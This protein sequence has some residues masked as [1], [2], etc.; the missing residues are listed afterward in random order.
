MTAVNNYHFIMKTRKDIN[1][2]IMEQAQKMT[3]ARFKTE[4]ELDHRIDVVKK[5]KQ[6]CQVFC[7][8]HMSVF[9][10]VIV[11]TNSKRLK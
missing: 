9:L 4:R 2:L 7:S 11:F 5:Q 8:L 3:R 10:L 1:D 6:K